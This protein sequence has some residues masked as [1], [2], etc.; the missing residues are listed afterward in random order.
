[1]KLYYQDIDP[2]A[3]ADD[4]YALFQAS[5]AVEAKLLKADDFPP[6]Q[7]SAAQ[8][9]T[10]QTRFLGCFRDEKLAALVEL[11]VQ[12]DG[13]HINSLVVHPNY[14]R[15]GIASQLL[16]KVFIQYPASVYEVETGKDN[17]PAIALYEREGFSIYGEYR[18]PCGILKVKMRKS[19]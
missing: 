12:T 8:I 16:D 10:S 5:Y 11:D 13:V 18:I 1:M 3:K 17:K 7:R 14:F 19:Q 9:A 15:Q 6:L 4:I 2:T